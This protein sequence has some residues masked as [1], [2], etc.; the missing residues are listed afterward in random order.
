M[1]ATRAASMSRVWNSSW[2]AAGSG[3]ISSRVSTCGD[4]WTLIQIIPRQVLM[5]PLIR[6]AVDIANQPE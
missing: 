6:T 1:T 5:L 2:R 4:R 3:F